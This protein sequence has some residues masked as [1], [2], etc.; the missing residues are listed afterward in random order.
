MRN[1]RNVSNAYIRIDTAGYA[2][3]A[4]VKLAILMRKTIG[5]I[6]QHLVKQRVMN[7]GNYKSIY[8]FAMK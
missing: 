8:G 7:A 2:G 5:C 1:V 4:A 6:S 3:E